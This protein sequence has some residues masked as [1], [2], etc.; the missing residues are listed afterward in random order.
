MQ[1]N[2]ALVE[3]LTKLINQFY[4]YGYVDVAR[5]LERAR[6]LALMQERERLIP[7]ATD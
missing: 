2:S 4:E 7:P 6:W 5:I 3:E 1:I